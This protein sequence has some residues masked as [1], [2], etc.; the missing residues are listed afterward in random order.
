MKVPN[1]GSAQI[2]G[3]KLR[4]YLLSPSHPIGRY[5]AR[6]FGNLGYTREDAGR[7]ATD[8]LEILANDIQDS[9]ETEFG[10]KYVV[11]GQRTAPMAQL[12]RSSRSGL[13]SPVRKLRHS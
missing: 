2:T 4:E 5:K 6:F 13:S 9:I 3:S 10:T 1:V 12:Q 8:L 7:L 11:P